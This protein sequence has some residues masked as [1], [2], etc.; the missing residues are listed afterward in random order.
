[1][2]ACRD[3]QVA[4]RASVLIPIMAALTTWQRACREYR[5]L[6]RRE[7]SRPMEQWVEQA[8]QVCN[9][10]PWPFS[11]FCSIVVMVIRVVVWVVEVILEWVVSLICEIIAVI[12]QVVVRVIAA[13]VEF[14]VAFFVCLFTDLEGFLN[15]FYDLYLA[16]LDIVESVIDLVG[17]IL[18][19]IIGIVESLGFLL[20]NVYIAV[21]SI[22]PFLGPALGRLLAGLIR[23]LFRLARRVLE[24]VR[25]IVDHVQ[26]IVFGVLRLDMCR[27]LTGLMGIGTDVGQVI[28]LAFNAFLSWTGGIRDS[29]ETGSISRP[30]DKDNLARIIDERLA[31]AFP[32]DPQAVIAAR[33]RIRLHSR[34]LG[35]PILLR[36]RRFYIGSRSTAVD[37]RALHRRGTLNLYTA[38]G[39]PNGCDGRTVTGAPHWEVVY[40]GTELAVSRRDVDAFLSVGP[41]AAPEFRVY[42]IRHANLERYL[43][44]ARRKGYEIGLD[45]GWA[46]VTDYAISFPDEL[47]FLLAS[48]ESI[49]GRF[50]RVGGGADALCDVPVLGIHLYGDLPTS[51]DPT[52]RVNPT[53][54]GQTSWF[55]PP[56]DRGRSGVSFR[57]RVPEFVFQWVLI[58]E[59]GHYFGL[60]H[61]GHD[62]MEHIM[63][64]AAPTEGLV[65]V[66]AGTVAEYVALTGEPRF[67]LEDARRVWDWLAANGQD[68]IRGR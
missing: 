36:P 11:W 2:S 68:C 27:T 1:M 23:Y 53:A 6:V 56:D 63:Y 20:E 17:V 42:G 4:M 32:S 38:M 51:G 60:D 3:F 41:M 61:A 16:V 43:R 67:T 58:H 25:D 66:T 39:G 37:L 14:V 62:G 12:V 49:L 30:E 33:A 18:D 45:L 31:R 26:D 64:T 65:P 13:V 44:V 46:P 21:L 59:L 19:A 24:I 7:V 5:E 15:A 54:N 50:G 52:A 35:L 28:L 48:H 47:P 29:F 55:R 34:P 9:D 22:I 8:Q 40:A 10:W 57:E